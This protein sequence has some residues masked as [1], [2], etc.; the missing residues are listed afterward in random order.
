MN[1]LTSKA[2]SRPPIDRA[3]QGAKGR[4]DRSL[5]SF[6]SGPVAILTIAR[7]QGIRKGTGD[8]HG[9]IVHPS[10]AVSVGL[11]LPVCQYPRLSMWMERIS[12]GPALHVDRQP[13]AQPSR[14]DSTLQYP[15]LPYLPKILSI[16]PELLLPASLVE[17]NPS[18]APKAE[19]V[20]YSYAPASRLE[21]R[22]GC[23]VTNIST[24]LVSASHPDL[25]HH[26]T[27]H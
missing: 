17:T 21:T 14:A 13:T 24:A 4:N 1:W 11:C 10:S 25:F 9:W 23:S 6:S 22:N 3:G 5:A 15:Y 16:Q 26:T 18:W 12:V 7:Q 20:Y 8:R 2:K 27:R 19:G